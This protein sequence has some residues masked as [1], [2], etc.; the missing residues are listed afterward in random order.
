MPGSSAKRPRRQPLPRPRGR[1]ILT[2]AVDLGDQIKKDDL[3]FQLDDR[4][5][6]IEKQQRE[7]QI[8]RARLTLD[9]SRRDY[10]RAQELI[11]E[12]LL[13]EQEFETARTAFELAKNSIQQG[14]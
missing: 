14:E 12:K 4:D 3:L 7:T 13:S 1:K 2:L 8:A 11:K 6:Q 10:E 9:Q 5:L